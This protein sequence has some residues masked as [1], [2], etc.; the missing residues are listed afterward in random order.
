VSVNQ[1]VV[2]DTGG[3]PMGKPAVVGTRYTSPIALIAPFTRSDLLSLL[4]RR[5]DSFDNIG[6]DGSTA[7]NAET[8]SG[9]ASGNRAQTLNTTNV[10][11]I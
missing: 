10:V 3:R 11:S 8:S 6:R 2:I 9:D 5:D 4:L 1:T 7:S